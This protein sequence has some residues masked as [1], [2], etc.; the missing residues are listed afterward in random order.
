LTL[1]TVIF[2][3]MLTSQVL[4][5]AI[6]AENSQELEGD[7][8]PQQFFQLKIQKLAKN[9]VYFGL[10]LRG[11]R[12]NRGNAPRLFRHLWVVRYY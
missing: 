2:F 4:R 8:F 11:L 6:T 9:S 5:E 3:R 12:G 7:G 1:P 10:H